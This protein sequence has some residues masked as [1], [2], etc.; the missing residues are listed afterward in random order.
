MSKGAHGSLI[1]FNT[2]Q[3]LGLV[4]SVNKIGSNWED[5]YPGFTKGI[6]KLTG[7]Q[8]K[9]YIDESVRPV[10]IT[11]R[12]FP[13]HVRPKIE[14]EE[15]R[16]LREDTIEVSFG[17]PTPWVSPIVTPPKKDGSIRLCIDLRE[18]NKAIIRERHNMPTLDELIHDL[19]G[20]TVFSKLDMSS[21][22]HQLELHPSSRYITTF[23]THNVL[24]KYK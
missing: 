7:V 12:K 21:G 24:Y 11:N 6:G 13:F 2:A 17:E 20:A 16:L 9:L 23:R 1:G 3:D 15:L 14:D 4:N 18:H 5:K 19:N 8:V 22:Y 10:A